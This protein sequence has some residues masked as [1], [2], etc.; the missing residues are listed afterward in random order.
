MTQ[1][2][3]WLHLAWADVRRLAY[4][5]AHVI[6][7]ET[8]QADA[9]VQGFQDQGRVRRGVETVRSGRSHTGTGFLHLGLGWVQLTRRHQQPIPEQTHALHRSWRHS[10]VVA[11]R[12][13]RLMLGC[14]LCQPGKPGSQSCSVPAGGRRRCSHGFRPPRALHPAPGSDNRERRQ[15][16]CSSAGPRWVWNIQWLTL[17]D[18]QCQKN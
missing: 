13:L 17:P 18:S 6:A 16:A 12:I 9:G 14:L 15:Y 4:I 11:G 1:P 8:V 2:R 5:L 7:P 3:T 10:I